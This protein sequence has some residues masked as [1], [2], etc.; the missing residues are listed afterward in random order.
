[1]LGLD[2]P[3]GVLD[4]RPLTAED[5]AALAD[6]LRAVASGGSRLDYLGPTMDS[7]PR[8]IR[9]DRGELASID[10]YTPDLRDQHVRIVDGVI[11][12]SIVVDQLVLALHQGR[13]A[14]VYPHL[15]QHP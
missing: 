13:A 1:M 9:I 7:H 4:E 11:E 15:G 5:V 8:Q 2:T 14:I 10:E 12:H 3:C 6:V